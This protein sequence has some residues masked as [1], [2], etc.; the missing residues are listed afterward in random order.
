MRSNHFR[1]ALWHL[2]IAVAIIACF[3]VL[4]GIPR[5]FLIICVLWSGALAAV[6]WASLR[7]QRR[8]AWWCFGI[9]ISILNCS[10]DGDTKPRTR[11]L[12]LGELAPAGGNMNQA[13]GAGL[14]ARQ[15]Q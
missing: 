15:R 8:R 3:L 13:G 4:L 12:G 5:G 6:F 14:R 9:W 2:M 10:P 11:Q 7:G 1:F